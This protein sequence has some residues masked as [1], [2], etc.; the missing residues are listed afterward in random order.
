[1]ACTTLPDCG[2]SQGSWLYVRRIRAEGMA[3]NH[4]A[5]K[6]GRI[7]SLRGHS[8]PDVSGTGRG[9]NH[10]GW[11]GAADRIG[12][13]GIPW[14]VRRHLAVHRGGVMPD[15]GLYRPLQPRLL[16][17]ERID[18]Q[19]HENRAFPRHRH[20]RGVHTVVFT[21]SRGPRG[22]RPCARAADPREPFHTTLDV[23]GHRQ[24]NAHNSATG[25]G[26]FSWS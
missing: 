13:G 16:R 1:M 22:H 9:R 12:R 3:Q 11:S 20:Q 2:R 17:A 25:C 18:T 10:T 15:A 26:R 5:Q 21:A 24:K 23:V 19:S 7:V 8:V 6:S 14:H 4:S